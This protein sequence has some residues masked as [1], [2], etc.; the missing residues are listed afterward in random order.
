MDKH[1]KI[2]IQE[3]KDIINTAQ[4]NKILDPVK[5][6]GD[7]FYDEIEELVHMLQRVG[8]PKGMEKI[9][10]GFTHYVEYSKYD[11]V[12]KELEVNLT[13][14]N[15]KKVNNITTNLLD[16]GY[17]IRDIMDDEPGFEVKYISVG[18]DSDMNMVL[19]ILYDV[20]HSAVY[21]TIE[22]DIFHNNIIQMPGLGIA[23][24]KDKILNNFRKYRDVINK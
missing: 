2:Y 1:V 24:N 16:N 18:S 9:F 12:L 22:D 17:T 13:L 6:H 8:M 10:P 7:L 4:W 20:N 21:I 5:I 23:Y 19:I 15:V 14:S 11:D 3:N